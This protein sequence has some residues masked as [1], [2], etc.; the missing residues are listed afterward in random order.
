MDS[1]RVFLLPGE[2]HVSRRPE[3]MATLLGSCVAVCLYNRQNGSAAMN[4]FLLPE[5]PPNPEK[6]KGHYGNTS[7]ETIL[8][9]M[10]KLGGNSGNMRARVY[11]GAAVVGHLGAASNIGIRNAE[12]AL[13]VL[14]QWHI[15]V[16]EKDTGGKTGRRIYFNTAKNEVTVRT[17]QKTGAAEDLRRK[18]EDIAGRNTRVLVVDDSSLVRKI[19]TRAIGGA[20]GLNVCG[21][22]ADA[23][24]ARDK[25]LALDPDVICLDIIMPRLDGLKFL[26]KLSMHFPKPVVICSTIAK[27]GSDVA[28]RAEEYG[29]VAVVDKD[30]LELYKGMDV[31]R[32]ELIPKLRMAAGRVVRKKMFT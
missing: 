3:T 17:V 4:H 22:A 12:V 8:Q 26:K 9:I 31:V 14:K 2:Y 28:K 13:A 29:A 20:S 7:T 16:I 15:R 19:L 10:E 30:K 23:F 32:K 11:G 24:D 1:D 27:A 5:A 25:I 18:R 21:E 6:D